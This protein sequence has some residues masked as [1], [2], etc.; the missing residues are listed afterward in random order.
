MEATKSLS[1]EEKECLEKFA[2]ESAD[3]KKFL[4]SKFEDGWYRLKRIQK[5]RKEE[6]VPLLV[7]RAGSSTLWAPAMC[8]VTCAGRSF[9]D[10]HTPRW[11]ASAV[12]LQAH[13]DITLRCVRNEWFAL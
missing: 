5:E 11:E 2:K 1:A 3:S 12:L 13:P 9:V 7:Q 8:A 4:A 10:R 6:V